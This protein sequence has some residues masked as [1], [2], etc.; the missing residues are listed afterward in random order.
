MLILQ[1]KQLRRIVQEYIAYF[2]TSRPHQ[3]ID[4]QI[5]A[6]V[7]NGSPWPVSPP[8]ADGKIISTPVLGGLHHRYAWAA[9]S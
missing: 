8:E 6:C 2:N 1:L 3:G 9:I 4:Q 5:P 7:A